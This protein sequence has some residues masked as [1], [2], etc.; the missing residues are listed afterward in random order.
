[1]YSRL[2]PSPLQGE[3]IDLPALLRPGYVALLLPPGRGKVGMG[4]VL[5]E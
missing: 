5:Y 3:G 1:M 2:S 4:V